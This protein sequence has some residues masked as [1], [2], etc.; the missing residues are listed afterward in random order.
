MNFKSGISGF[1]IGVVLT[2]SITI[3][4]ETQLNVKPNPYPIIVDGKTISTE[5]YNINGS[6]YLGLTATANILDV[7]VKFEDKKILI[8]TQ[9]ES[10]TP[11]KDYSVPE[12]TESYQLPEKSKVTDPNEIL[13]LKDNDVEHIVYKNLSAIEYNGDIFV[14]SK[15]LVSQKHIISQIFLKTKTIILYLKDEPIAKTSNFN[16]DFLTYNGNFYFNINL[17]NGYLD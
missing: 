3:F 1:L 12:H 10:K 5:G 7:D 11:L 8:T 4:A 6:T 15:D 14:N 9:T 2:S 17:L 13:S 16:K